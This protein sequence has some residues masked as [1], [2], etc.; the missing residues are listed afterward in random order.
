MAVVAIL[1]L[2][3]LRQPLVIWLSVPL[4]LIC[5]I[6][7]LIVTTTPL[8]LVANLAVLSLPRMLLKNAIV[9]TD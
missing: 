7:S 5:L 4:S 1:L 6:F 9:L 2:N 3:A 8:E